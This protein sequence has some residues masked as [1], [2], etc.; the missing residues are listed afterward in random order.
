MFHIA[1][2]EEIKAGQL[3]DVYFVRTMEILKAKKILYDL[4]TPQVIREYVLKQL[5]HFDL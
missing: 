5:P 4:P 2:P 3:T 1:D